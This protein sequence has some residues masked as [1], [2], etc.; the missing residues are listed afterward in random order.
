MVMVGLVLGQ[1]R[2]NVSVSNLLTMIYWLGSHVKP[3]N[4]PW[5]EKD[6]ST[7]LPERP[8]R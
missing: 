2:H 4:P 5:D 6:A 3:T 1:L 8:C 7:L